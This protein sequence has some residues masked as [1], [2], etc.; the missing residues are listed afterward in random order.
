MSQRSESTEKAL[1][2]I[3]KITTALVIPALVWSFKLSTQVTV[4]EQKLIAQEKELVQMRDDF[5]E[6]INAG[7]EKLSKIYETLIKQ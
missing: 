6:Q 1:D 3:F 5:K 2:W 4:L 7:N